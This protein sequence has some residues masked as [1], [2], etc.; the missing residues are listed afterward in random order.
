MLPCQLEVTAKRQTLPF[1][2]GEGGPATPDLETGSSPGTSWGP[3]GLECR[4]CD[5]LKEMKCRAA[6]HIGR[7][8]LFPGKA[9]LVLEIWASGK[10]THD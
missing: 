10:Q 4:A 1:L 2:T 7:C 9:D 5:H 8:S 3:G 6:V